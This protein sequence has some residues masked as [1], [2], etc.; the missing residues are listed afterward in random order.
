MNDP[1]VGKRK[2]AFESHRGET[3]DGAGERWHD[4]GPG[5]GA[6]PPDG[7]ST[8]RIE[9][10]TDIAGGRCEAFALDIFGE[11]DRDHARLRTDLKF[12]GNPGI[13]ENAVKN[14]LD[15]FRC[16]LKPQTISAI[17]PGEHQRQPAGAV[18]EILQRLR[19]G[20]RGVR[21][22]DP[23]R[24]LPRRGGAPARDRR[25]VGGTPIDR[26]DPHAV[27]GLADQ[28][29]ER[30]ALQHAIDQLAPVV[31]ACGREIRSQSQVVSHGCHSATVSF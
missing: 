25:G 10:E 9:A 18:R 3:F 17:S 22:I 19:I 20:P 15:R 26:F 1:S 11:V 14:S 2:R 5:V 7:A 24:D 13:D 31:V 23:L 28:L 6:G 8:D 30:R 29:L 27:I 16:R 4:L 12:E 21:M